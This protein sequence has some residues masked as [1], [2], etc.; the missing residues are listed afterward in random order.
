MI[1]TAI[2]SWVPRESSTRAIRSVAIGRDV[3]IGVT[4]RAIGGALA[5]RAT[6]SGVTARAAAAAA[7]GG[8]IVLL[9]PFTGANGSADG[10]FERIGGGSYDAS[11]AASAP[12]RSWTSR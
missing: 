9:G 5:A 10:A 4:A 2:I 8:G 6:G 3:G 11:A 1:A 7:I 12:D